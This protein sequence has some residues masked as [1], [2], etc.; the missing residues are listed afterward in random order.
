MILEFSLRTTHC[1]VWS[2][3]AQPGG[4][5]PSVHIARGVP[6][7]RTGPRPLLPCRAGATHTCV[8]SP[9]QGLQGRGGRPLQGTGAEAVALGRQPFRP[10]LT[11]APLA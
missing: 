7:M 1:Q 10:G 8:G 4:D 6:R 5:G 9:G 2:D 3:S 11:P